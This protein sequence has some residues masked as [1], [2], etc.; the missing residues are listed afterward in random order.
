VF[1]LWGF[2]QPVHSL[3]FSPDGRMLATDSP[4]EGLKLWDASPLTADHSARRQAIALVERLFR[5]SLPP[6]EVIDRLHADQTITDS[7][8]QHA[9][10]LAKPYGQ[11]LVRR[12]ADALI[13]SLPLGLLLRQELLDAV[14]TAPG[15]T[16]AVRQEALAQAERYVENTELVHRAS[17]DAVRR[18]DLEAAAYRLALR[19]VEVAVRLSP[20]NREYLTTLGMAH[21]RLGEYP[22][23]LDGLQRA[24]H[25]YADG[26]EA[27]PPAL[28][29][30]LAMTQHRLGN[31]PEARLALERL[32]ATVRQPQW[33]MKEEARAALAEAEAEVTGRPG[34]PPK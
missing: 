9:L 24:E 18:S 23:A 19:R 28:L 30:F 34:D 32:R 17:R 6:A 4:N 14:L 21:Y 15:V 1:R 13:R 22:K 27:P 5:Q 29:A 33:S 7:V 3:A 31:K 25:L 2:E 8:R 20:D 12:D 16:D 11:G 26:D 10:D